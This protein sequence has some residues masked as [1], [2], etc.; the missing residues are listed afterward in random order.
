MI[1]QTF[2]IVNMLHHHINEVKLF[3]FLV[4]MMMKPNHL[5]TTMIIAKMVVVGTMMVG[6]LMAG[7]VVEVL[8]ALHKE[9]GGSKVHMVLLSW[10]S[11]GL[12]MPPKMRIIVLGIC[13]VLTRTAKVEIDAHVTIL[14]R[15]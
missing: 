15:P 4:V 6:E 13:N 3:V 1:R 10:K 2:M 11:R 14:H 9:G 7:E 12:P 8:L 5:A